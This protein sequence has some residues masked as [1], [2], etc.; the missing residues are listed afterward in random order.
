MYVDKR[1]TFTKLWRIF[2]REKTQSP[3]K[4]IDGHPNSLTTEFD[5]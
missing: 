1:E 2:E 3:L 5:I 4:V